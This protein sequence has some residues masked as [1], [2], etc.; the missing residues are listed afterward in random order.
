MMYLRSAI[1]LHF[2]SQKYID[3]GRN[4]Q[5]DKEEMEE[6]EKDDNNIFHQI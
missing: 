1:Q 3:C 5:Y 4:L 2:I 6:K